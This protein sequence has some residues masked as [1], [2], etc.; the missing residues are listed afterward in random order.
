[1]DS[2]FVLDPYFGELSDP[3]SLINYIYTPL[4]LKTKVDVQYYEI[5]TGRGLV[6]WTLTLV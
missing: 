5:L 3:D 1:M 4:F 6:Y 2:K